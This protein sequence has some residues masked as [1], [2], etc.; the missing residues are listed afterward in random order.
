M[1]PFPFVSDFRLLLRTHLLNDPSFFF[2]G[3]GGVVNRS[4]G[5]GVGG[6]FFLKI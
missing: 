4:G 3:G 6:E 2:G 1:T 5:G